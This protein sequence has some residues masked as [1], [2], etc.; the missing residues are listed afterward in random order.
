MRNKIETRWNQL[1]NQNVVS[2]PYLKDE[3][4]RQWG[5]VAQNVINH[6][7][8]YKK[9]FGGTAGPIEQ[10]PY[11]RQFEEDFDIRR[12]KLII[13]PFP[14]RYNDKVNIDY[15]FGDSIDVWYYFF[16]IE[17]LQNAI[18]PVELIRNTL[19]ERSI[20]ITDVFEYIQR[21]GP[22]E[23]NVGNHGNL[24]LNTE[25][26]RALSHGSGVK[27]IFLLSGELNSLTDVG[28][29][30]VNTTKGVYWVLQEENKLDKYFIS[31]E[32]TGNDDS[33]HHFN[34]EG[35]K[36]AVAQQ[37]GGIIWWI[38]YG[39]KKVKMISLPNPS[40]GAAINGMIEY[41][42]FFER[43]VSYKAIYEGIPAPNEIEWPALNDYVA[44]YPAVFGEKAITKLY[45]R[46]VYQMALAGTLHEI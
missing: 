8:S 28:E 40:P 25:I 5:K 4:I 46:E 39:K 16:G 37:N 19:V 13:G 36:A 20:S 23:G 35:I 33:F 1:V 21:Q 2:T 31:G 24:V 6:R 7:E 9:T 14:A 18:N 32:I 38:K 22:E 26:R 17:D 43:W 42:G 15:Y 41:G 11:I 3:A 12:E 30:N 29:G 10:H 27:T 34:N 45:R 44:H